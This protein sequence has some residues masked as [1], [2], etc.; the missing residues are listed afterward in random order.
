MKSIP[1]CMEGG[2]SGSI[3][4]VDE[5]NPDPLVCHSG[6]KWKKLMRIVYERG[7]DYGIVE[8]RHSTFSKLFFFRSHGLAPKS[9][10]DILMRDSSWKVDQRTTRATRVS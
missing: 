8:Y 10:V 1:S 2:H 7:I 9:N 5:C 6:V 4:L 3:Y